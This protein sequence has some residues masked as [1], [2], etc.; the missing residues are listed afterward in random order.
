MFGAST[1]FTAGLSLAG[2]G[3]GLYGT[4]QQVKLAKDKAAQE[5]AIAQDEQKAEGVKYSAMITDSRRRELEV[6]RNAQRAR[7]MAVS[8]AVN[9]GAGA[10]GNNYGSGLPGGEGEISATAAT[11]EV[12]IQ[13]SM[14]FGTEMFGINSDISA[15]R[16]K[17]AQI[18][19]DMATAQGYSALGSSLVSAA[20]A[21]G[22]I[23]G[24]FG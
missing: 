14:K 6:Y 8:S 16:W 23:F 21:F 1:L 4:E 22:R 10:G 3:L 11:A 2:I 18:S 17:E 5:Q 13:N 20:P 19:G 7:A 15:H 24:S 9:Q 12:G